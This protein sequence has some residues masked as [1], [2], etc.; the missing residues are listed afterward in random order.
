MLNP[1]RHHRVTST[2]E[3]KAAAP[4]DCQ[5]TP[6]SPDRAEQQVDQT[7]VLVE[8]QQPHQRGGHPGDRH[9]HD[10]G[11][12]QRRP[13]PAAPS[14]AARPQGQSQPHRDR[15]DQ[16]GE[17]H[18]V[19]RRAPEQRI[20]GQPAGSCPAPRTFPSRTRPCFCR[21][22][23]TAPTSGTNTNSPSSTRLGPRNAYAA[24]GLPWSGP[25]SATARSS[26][27]SH[28]AV[29]SAMPLDSPWHG[30]VHALAADERLLQLV[31][32][33]GDDLGHVG[34]GDLAGVLRLDRRGLPD[35][36]R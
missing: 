35:E 6:G 24:T 30:V 8:D 17:Q 27:R 32:E 34:R 12:P 1:T 7:A 11:R 22:S 5:L 13:R 9:R 21:L 3:A 4:P 20:A 15:G 31:L 19:G 2:T 26:G 36:H 10:H 29:A 33:H 16:H 14:S 28:W 18:R 25:R 23:T